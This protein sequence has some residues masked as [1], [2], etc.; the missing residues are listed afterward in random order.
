MSI[1]NFIGFYSN[2]WAPIGR[3]NERDIK[4]ENHGMPG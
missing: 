3:N 1:P 2:A 4:Y